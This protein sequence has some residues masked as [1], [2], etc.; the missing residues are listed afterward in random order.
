VYDFITK[1]TQAGSGYPDRCPSVFRNPLDP[2][3]G[4]YPDLL[5]GGWPLT[6]YVCNAQAFRGRPNIQSTFPDGTSNTLLFSE[7]YGWDC[8]G[9]MF[10]YLNSVP[11]ARALSKENPF[12]NTAGQARATFADLECGDF[13]SPTTGTTFQVAPA[14]RDCDPRMPASSTQAGLQVGV[15]DGSVRLLSPG[16]APAVFWGMITPNGGEVINFD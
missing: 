14:I 2:S 10:V 9:T 3:I 11:R 16:I 7:Q 13:H 4:R 15:A 8:G 6:S 12:N 1:L 5:A